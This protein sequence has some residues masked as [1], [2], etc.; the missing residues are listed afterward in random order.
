MEYTD[1]T[2]DK[3]FIRID[4]LCGKSIMVENIPSNDIFNPITDLTVFNDRLIRKD[5]VEDTI[6]EGK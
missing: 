6:F 4:G 1:A 3:V 2:R 5:I